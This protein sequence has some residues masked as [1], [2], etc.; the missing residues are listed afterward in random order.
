MCITLLNVMD[1]LD[2]ETPNKAPTVGKEQLCARQH[3]VKARGV[4][5]GVG[6]VFIF[7]GFFAKTESQ[8][9]AQVQMFTCLV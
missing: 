3:K 2:S 5:G 7:V 8:H 1:A 9:L 4:S 6:V